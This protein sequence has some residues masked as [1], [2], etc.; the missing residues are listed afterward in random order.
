MAR[1]E[2]FQ[3]QA[4]YVLVNRVGSDRDPKIEATNGLTGHEVL[5]QVLTERFDSTKARGH[6]P[7]EDHALAHY[8]CPAQ[9]LQEAHASSVEGI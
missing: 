7:A 1:P 8:G 2:V 3:R 9:S 6:R 4:S 5:G